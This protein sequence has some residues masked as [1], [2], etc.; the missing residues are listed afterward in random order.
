MRQIG[1]IVEILLQRVRQSGGLA[2]PVDIATQIYSLCEQLVNLATAR[3]T[4]TA[5]LAP[6]LY[7]LLYNYRNEIPDAIGIKPNPVVNFFVL[8]QSTIF[9]LIR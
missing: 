5:T 1:P 9:P 3:I 6:P 7:K 4:G 8:I 2:T